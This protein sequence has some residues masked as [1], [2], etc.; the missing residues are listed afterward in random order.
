MASTVVFYDGICGLCNRFVRFLIRRDAHAR[1]LYAPLQGTLASSILPAH[2]HDPSDLDSVYVVVRW[3]DSTEQVLARS[4]AILHA[5]AELGPGW[6]A[7]ATMGRLVPQSWSDAMYSAIARRRY[8][9][10]GKYGACPV[11]PPEWRG[12]FIE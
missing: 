12:R 10:F 11:S 2:G 7:V 6:R 9:T 4:R 8:Q 3:G 1:L 5:L